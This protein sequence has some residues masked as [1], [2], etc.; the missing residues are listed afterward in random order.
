MASVRPTVT[1]F[2]SGDPA[3]GDEEYELA[4]QV[5][6]TLGAMGYRIANGGYGG[7][8]EASARG[9]TQVGAATVG[10]TCR[11]WKTRPNEYIDE[12]IE[13]AAMGERISTL[14]ELGDCGYVVLPGAT[15]TL[16]ELAWVW[17]LAC[18]KFL[19][20]RAARPIVC[21]GEFW[22][23]LIEMMVAQRPSSGRLVAVA[24]DAG[25]LER[26]FPDFANR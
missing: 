25:E 21:M 5:G 1:V 9:A 10:V 4:R 14:I 15:G 18:K 3:A 20:D 2:G 22:R 11:L 26:L 6:L 12:V 16:A 17:E 19:P 8:M 24:T 23:P 7:A 13:T